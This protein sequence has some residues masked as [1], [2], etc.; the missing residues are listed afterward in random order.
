M[1]TF[2]SSP[3]PFQDLAAKNQRLAIQSWVKVHPD[4]EV[5]IYGDG[6]GV[7]EACHELGVRHIP[8]IQCSDSGVPY[9]N[10]IVEHASKNARYNI[11]CYLNCDIIMT[12]ELMSSIHF[13]E[14]PRFLIIGQ[15]I[16]LAEG[17]ASGMDLNQLKKNDLIELSE[18]GKAIL[19]E[20]G[21][22]DYFIFPRGIWVGLPPLVIGRGGYDNALITFCL[23]KKIPLINATLAF[24]AL[25]LFHNYNHV[26]GGKETVYIGKDAQ[27][28]LL[29]HKIKHSL[30]DST[31]AS[32]LIENDK[33]IPNL[34]QNDW[35]KRIE[36]KLRFDLKINFLSL[37]IRLLWRLFVSY[38]I[39]KPKI[40][41]IK[42]IINSAM[43]Y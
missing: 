17:V 33:L 10:S 36:L 42:D 29:L 8:E 37:I 20:P 7:S 35:L 9:F 38:G 23:R 26:S 6:V 34:A 2:L 15:R 3:K 1:I 21:A 18:K 43:K 11:Q 22:I 32:W 41:T 28:N 12:K 39:I 30:P 40:F 4:A 14:F 27:D 13:I 24:P 5:I 19:Q 25:H 16:D 31:Y